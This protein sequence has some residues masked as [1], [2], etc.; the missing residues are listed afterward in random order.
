MAPLVTERFRTTFRALRYRDFRL[1]FA[2]Q[3]LSL[4]G[5]WMQQVAMSWLMYRL[6]GSAFM[7][8]A[9]AFA[10]QFPSFLMA[11]VAGVLADRLSRHRIVIATQALSMLQAA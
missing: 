7:L 6:T 11:P 2:G 9:M 3:G 1:F 8:G 4:V 5:T 10:T